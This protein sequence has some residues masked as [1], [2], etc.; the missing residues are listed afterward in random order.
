MHGK[1]LGRGFVLWTQNNFNWISFLFANSQITCT[2]WM[3]IRLKLMHAHSQQICIYAH[4]FT[5]QFPETKETEWASDEDTP[6]KQQKRNAFEK[7]AQIY[8]ENGK[9]MVIGEGYTYRLPLSLELYRNISLSA[10]KQHQ[11]AHFRRKMYH[12][13]LLIWNEYGP[14]VYVTFNIALSPL[15]LY[16]YHLLSSTTVYSIFDYSFLCLIRSISSINK[17][18]SL[19]NE[20]NS[21]QCK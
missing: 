7:N 3:L 11:Y 6:K 13:L 18:K 4:C 15:S 5:S 1:L 16:L 8:S 14:I 19:A 20:E 12:K 17:Q 21:L 10:S 9:W 2:Q